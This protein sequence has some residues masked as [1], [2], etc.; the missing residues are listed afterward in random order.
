MTLVD[1]SLEVADSDPTP[2][3]AAGFAEL[4]G[5][6]EEQLHRRIVGQ[7]PVNSALST[8]Q[9]YA[10]TIGNGYRR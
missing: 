9:K 1:H 7:Q 5:R 2:L 8:S 4:A 3:T 6:L 10:Q